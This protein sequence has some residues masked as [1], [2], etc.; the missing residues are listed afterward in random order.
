MNNR[1]SNFQIIGD[2]LRL[3]EAGKTEIMYS[4]NMSHYQLGRYLDFLI[5]RGFLKGPRKK[6]GVSNSN[7]GGTYRVTVSGRK[8]L[9]QIDRLAELLGW[10]EE[11]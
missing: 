4:V 10:E 7:S 9:K 3:S 5:E 1:R 6:P 2:I 8:L 11:Y